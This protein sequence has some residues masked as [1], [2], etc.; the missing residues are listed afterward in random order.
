MT[1]CDHCGAEYT[2]PLAAAFCCDPAAFGDT[3]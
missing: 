2:S 1:T 3:D